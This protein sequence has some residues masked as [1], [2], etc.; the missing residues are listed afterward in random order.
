MPTMDN[1]HALVVG[2]ANY[3]QANPLPDTVLQEAEEIHA[4]LGDPKHGG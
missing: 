3:Q 4:L 2:I 1:A